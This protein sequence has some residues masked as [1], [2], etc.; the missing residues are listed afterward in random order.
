MPAFLT[1]MEA[2]QELSFIAVLE[3]TVLENKNV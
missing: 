2:L 1:A 3:N